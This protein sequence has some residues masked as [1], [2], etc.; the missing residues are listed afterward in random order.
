MALIRII[1]DKFTWIQ[2]IDF[3]SLMTL[4]I[5]WV[6]HDHIFLR[7]HIVLLS[8]LK[9]GVDLPHAL[10]VATSLFCVIPLVPLLSPP[11]LEKSWGLGFSVTIP[12][13]QRIPTFMIEKNY[14]PLGM[15]I[16]SP[17][18]ILQTIRFLMQ[19]GQISKLRSILTTLLIFSIIYIYYYQWIW[20]AWLV[21]GFERGF[22]GRTAI[23]AESA[24]YSFLCQAITFLLTPT[25]ARAFGNQHQKLYVVYSGVL[26]T[27][28]LFLP[29]VGFMAVILAPG[30]P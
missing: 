29:K 6:L 25:I 11:V 21:A 7:H 4:F 19:V 12:F 24:V 2:K 27:T 23:V 22:A 18:L 14:L 20:N 30:H 13:F 3:L 8:K 17:F 16:V 28:L 1:F 9:T 26:L 5:L 10:T 15:I